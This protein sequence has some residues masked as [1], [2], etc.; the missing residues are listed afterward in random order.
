MA[1]SS[2]SQVRQVIPTQVLL[3]ISILSLTKEVLT[4]P[5]IQINEQT[6]QRAAQ[7]LLISLTLHNKLGQTQYVNLISRREY[8]A[9][10]DIK[11]AT[12]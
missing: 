8:Y 10:T 6:N 7:A 3:S 12:P 11:W 4:A 1:V 2:C 5:N 9:S